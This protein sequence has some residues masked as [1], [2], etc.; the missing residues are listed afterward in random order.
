M[1][2]MPSRQC[3][4]DLNGKPMEEKSTLDLIILTLV[5]R[6]WRVAIELHPVHAT[7]YR[8][9]VSR[10]TPRGLAQFNNR[11]EF[12]ELEQG[13]RLLEQRVA[14]WEKEQPSFKK[15]AP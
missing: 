4:V 15:N 2:W 10:D 12:F 6:G 1:P 8:L 13:M 14:A 5:N 11:C 9:I 3:Y 7:R